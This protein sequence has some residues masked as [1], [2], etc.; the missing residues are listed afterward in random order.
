VQESNIFDPAQKVVLEAK[1]QLLEAVS[2]SQ[3]LQSQ[4]TET[5]QRLTASALKTHELNH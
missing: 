2:T 3:Q 4:L 1:T 5:K